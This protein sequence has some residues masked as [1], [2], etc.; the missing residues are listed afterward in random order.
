MQEEFELINN[1]EKQRYEFHVD[2]YRPLI[3]YTINREGVIFL[4]HT[5][6]S[7]AIEGEGIGSQLAEAVLKDIE[8]RKL[9]LVP[10]CPFISRYVS[11]HPEWRRILRRIEVE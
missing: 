8:K 9:Q 2:H 1:E 5:E 6:V 7:L 10:V 3:E 4:T 11:K